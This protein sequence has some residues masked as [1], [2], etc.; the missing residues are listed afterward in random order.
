[1]GV[2]GGRPGQLS[3]GRQAVLRVARPATWNV[4]Q[5]SLSAFKADFSLAV[6]LGTI[7]AARAGI[8]FPNAGQCILTCLGAVPGVYELRAATTSALSAFIAGTPSSYYRFCNS[9]VAAGSAIVRAFTLSTHTDVLR[10][11]VITNT[12]LTITGFQLWRTA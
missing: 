6:P 3:I 9:S 10:I 7:D 12:A 5:V 8:V 2:T 4:D 1:M 11:G